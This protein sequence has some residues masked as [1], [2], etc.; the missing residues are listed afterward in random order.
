MKLYSVFLIALLLIGILTISGCVKV[1]SGT[2]NN[3]TVTVPEPEEIEPPEGGEEDEEGEGGAIAS[4]TSL[5][6]KVDV[7]SP[8]GTIKYRERARKIGTGNTDF[9]LDSS[10]NGATTSWIL[11]KG[12]QLGWVCAGGECS[13]L[14][15][16]PG[17]DFSTYWGNYYNNGFEAYIGYL[18]GW[19]SGELTMT[20]AGIT[21]KFYDIQVN[22]TIPDSVF[23]HS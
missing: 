8:G 11:S 22:P 19:N 5:D 4:A 20:F 14:P 16:I 12:T 9:R 18:A 21:Y 7:T 15:D 6:F 17:M 3:F 13:P 1:P 10:T 2:T 23:Q